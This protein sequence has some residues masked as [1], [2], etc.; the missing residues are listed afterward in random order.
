MNLKNKLGVVVVMTTS[1]L[2]F[3]MEIK[4]TIL[5]IDQATHL[6]WAVWKHGSLDSY[7]DK[8]FS[9]Y[10][11]DC[12]IKLNKIKHFVNKLIDEFK[13]ELIVVEGIQYQSN[14]FTY[15]QL[16]RLQ[17]L[18]IDLCVEGNYLYEVVPPSTWR[19]I[20]IKGRKRVEQ[21]KSSVQFVKDN[22]GL[23]VNDDVADAINMG[24]YALKNIE[25]KQK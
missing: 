24:F 15:A 18:L 7:G 12:N 3:Y 9:N 6:G 21:K 11:F 22:F 1:T 14:Q 5:S 10:K 23:D 8:N 2:F 4:M 19:T 13:P 20:G 16:A 25:V 17:G